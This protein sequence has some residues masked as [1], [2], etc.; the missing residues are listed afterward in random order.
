MRLAR[1]MSPAAPPTGWKWRW[2][3][4]TARTRGAPDEGAG[5]LF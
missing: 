1:I 2:V 5:S 4:T 3:K